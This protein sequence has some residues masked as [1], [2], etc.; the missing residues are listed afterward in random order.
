M[1]LKYLNINVIQ[2]K[3]LRFYVFVSSKIYQ[4]TYHKDAKYKIYP[5]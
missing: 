5:R 1:H 3:F 2:L 4:S